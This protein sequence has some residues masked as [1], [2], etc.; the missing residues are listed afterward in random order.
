VGGSALYVYGVVAADDAASLP[1][2][3]AAI[4][5]FPLELVREG[6]LAA[7][8]GEVETEPFRAG[9]RAAEDGDLAWLA[10]AAQA[11]EAVLAGAL[12][13]GA[14]LPFRFGMLVDTRD[15]VRALLAAQAGAFGARLAALRGAREWG[16]KALLRRGELEAA[17]AAD[18]PALA[19]LRE[20]GQAGSGSAFF[21]R[22]QF[23]REVAERLRDAV[24][25]L[26]ETI[27]DRLAGRA[28]EATANPPQARELSGYEDDMILNGAYLVDR[29]REPEL[30]AAAAGLEAELTGR[31]VRLELTGP[32]PAYNFVDPA[33]EPVA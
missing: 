32:W 14:L 15:D 23:E 3:G 6:D 12:G 27:H 30:R 18:E 19:E 24:A 5:A 4:D 10:R 13:A 21:A 31:G 9:V 17:L 28:R 16:V 11:H 33:A 25:E 1:L 29:D 8:A 22:K 20:R 26:A 2:D 7:L